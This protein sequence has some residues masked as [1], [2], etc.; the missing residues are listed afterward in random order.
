MILPPPFLRLLLGPDP[1]RHAT[2]SLNLWVAVFYVFNACLIAIALPMGSVSP[3]LTPFAITCMLI[4]PAVFYGLLRSGWRQRWPTDPDLIMAQSVYCAFAVA[5]GYMTV[6]VN[7]RGVVLTLM[8]AIF[9]PGQFA[10]SPRRIRQLTVVMVML[11]LLATSLNWV[12]DPTPPQPLGDVMRCTYV[13]AALLASSMVAQHVSRTHYETK[14]KSDALANALFKVEHMASHDQL[15][16]LINRHRMHEV[17]DKEWQRLQR[18]HR[19]TTMIMMDLDHFKH[20]NDKLGHQVGDE[21]LKQFSVLA[22]TYLRDADVVS[23]WGG[24]EFLVL[25]PDTTCEQAMVGLNRLRDQMHTQPFLA[26]H[27]D[28]KV[29]FSAGLA[30]VQP[31][32]SM[33]NVIDRADRALYAA[34]RSGRDRFVQSP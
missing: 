14:A 7:L 21:V 3:T 4:G 29:T 27:P 34:K 6:N 16:G 30:M 8:P 11:I 17:L 12:L 33:T 24:E 18:R 20:V 10:L 5:V 23:R 1:D 9:L 15:T 22:D 2:I 31:S 26:Q 32:E 19:P 28:L 25:C 13:I